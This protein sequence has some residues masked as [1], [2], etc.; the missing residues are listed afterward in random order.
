MQYLNRGNSWGWTR[1]RMPSLCTGQKTTHI[2]WYSQGAVP[3]GPVRPAA[4]TRRG[5]FTHCD[6]RDSER[7]CLTLGTQREDVNDFIKHDCILEG[8]GQVLSGSASIP[9]LTLSSWRQRSRLLDRISS[10]DPNERDV[11]ETLGD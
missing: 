11:L 3:Q 8:D 5:M 4:P 6:S 10:K 1:Q 9:R 2:P 7:G